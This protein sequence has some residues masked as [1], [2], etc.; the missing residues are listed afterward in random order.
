MKKIT[1]ESDISEI[2]LCVVQ[3]RPKRDFISHTGIGLLGDSLRMKL[4]GI[5]TSCKTCQV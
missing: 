3:G 5:K 2:E 1:R 4:F